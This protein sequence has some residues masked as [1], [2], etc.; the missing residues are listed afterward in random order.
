MTHILASV[1]FSVIA[2]ATFAFVMLMLVASR[3][4]IM[5]ALGVDRAARTVTPHHPVRVRSAGR[6]QA[7]QVVAASQRR[8]AA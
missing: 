3:D 5:L 6:W 2:I 8:A 4:A 1:G 7:A